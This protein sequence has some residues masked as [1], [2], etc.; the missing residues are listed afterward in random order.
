MSLTDNPRAVAGDNQS[1]AYAQ[2]VTE[3]MAR[4]YA[5]LV[6]S[7]EAMLAKA[8]AA[9]ADVDSD[10]TAL[11]VGA[12]VKE[13]RD[14]DRRAEAYRMA[15]KEPHLRAEQ[16]V[17]QFFFELRDKLAKRNRNDR[18][19][20]AGAADILQ[21][22]IDQHLERKRIAEQERRRREAEETARIAREAAEREARLRREEEEAR[23]AAERARKPENVAAH[24]AKA[25]QAGQAAA[26]ATVEAQVTQEKAVDAHIG[27]L[28]RPADLVRTRGGGVLL[29][30]ARVGYAVLVDRALVD[31]NALRPYFTEQ[32]LEKALRGWAKAV[33]YGQPM[34][35]AEVGFR[36]KGQTR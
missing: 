11:A 35:G 12:I 4:E 33:N 9:P 21:A 18:S 32:E 24:T 30:E 20:R 25:E 10:E 19:A 1:P 3:Q 7:V 2:R 22:R 6:D 5:A 23:A 17:D 8:A 34:P 15:E 14:T 29:T 36:Q 28:A 13:I 26:A 27:T 31:M 16:A